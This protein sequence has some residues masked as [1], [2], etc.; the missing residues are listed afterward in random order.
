MLWNG[1]EIPIQ[2]NTLFNGPIVETFVKKC[3][4]CTRIVNT[5][6]LDGETVPVGK[7]L[8]IGDSL[9]V[10]MGND[11]NLVFKTGQEVALDEMKAM[12]LGF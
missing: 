6:E 12:N 8:R 5:Y 10:L 9:T 4:N 1:I 2:N 11:G 3:S 7:T